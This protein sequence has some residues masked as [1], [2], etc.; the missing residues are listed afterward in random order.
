MK[1]IKVIYFSIKAAIKPTIQTHKEVQLLDHRRR[2]GR[3]CRRRRLCRCRRR[4]RR[5]CNCCAEL[6]NPDKMP[7]KH[8]PN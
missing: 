1:K 7:Q 6:P 4:H 3:R 5:G 8:F 2:C